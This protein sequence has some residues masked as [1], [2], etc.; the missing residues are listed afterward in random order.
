MFNL[1]SDPLKVGAQAP[2]QEVTLQS[3]DALDLAD[4]YNEGTVLVYFYPKA[5]TPG[6]TAQACSLR[7]AFAE[8]SGANLKVLGV[9]G[10]SPEKLTAFR[11]KFALPFDLVSDPDGELMKA[12]GVPHVLGISARQAF[13]ISEGKVIW[14]DT[15]ASTRKQ[16]EDVLAALNSHNAAR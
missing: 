8:I 10:D 15:S 12:F 16:A 1:F 11:E 4:V 13:L 3:G 7:D 14:R 2:L 5:D 9:S 6:C